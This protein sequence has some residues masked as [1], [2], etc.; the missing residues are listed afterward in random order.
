MFEVVTPDNNG[1][2]TCPIC[3]AKASESAWRNRSINHEPSTCPSNSSKCRGNYVHITER[4]SPN[5]L[6]GRLRGIA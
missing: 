6:S 1:D 2:I 4:A 5:A 3:H